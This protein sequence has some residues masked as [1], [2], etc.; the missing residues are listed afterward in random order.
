MGFEEVI[1][2]Q[3]KQK[4]VYWGN[5]VNDGHGGFTFDNPIE[6]NCRWEDMQQIVSDK[7]GNEI[8]SRAV[9]YVPQD[10]DEEGMLYLGTLESL[11]ELDGD[12]DSSSGG[13]DNPRDI[14]KTYIIKRFKKTPA[15]GSTTNFLRA[16][17]LTPSL[18]FGGF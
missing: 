10:L 11:Y 12:S 6:I 16:A 5:P 14:D 17:F 18:S 1:A 4:C 9:V 15:L 13:V 2:R 8:T 3:Y 7:Y